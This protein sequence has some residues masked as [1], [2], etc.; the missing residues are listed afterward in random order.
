MAKKVAIWHNVDFELMKSIQ[1]IFPIK[2]CIKC[3]GVFI[4]K[5]KVNYHEAFCS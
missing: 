5:L 2:I 1:K 3:R 4:I